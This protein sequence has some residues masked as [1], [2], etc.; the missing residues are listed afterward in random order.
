MP[1]RPPTLP[2]SGL[3]PSHPAM[4]AALTLTPRCNLFPVCLSFCPDS[5]RLWGSLMS[6]SQPRHD[7]AK[8]NRH[9]L[10]RLSTTESSCQ[11]LECVGVSVC[12]PLFAHWQAAG[13]LSH[14]MNMRLC[15][16]LQLRE[17]KLVRSRCQERRVC[18]VRWTRC[19]NK[20]QNN[21]HL[22][23]RVPLTAFFALSFD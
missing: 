17:W 1:R 3:G 14:Y 10:V 16:S 20:L 6:L 4:T 8:K 21:V 23:S 18:A 19:E 15:S 13:S 11:E 5:I 22:L 12:R 7:S 2:T 9:L